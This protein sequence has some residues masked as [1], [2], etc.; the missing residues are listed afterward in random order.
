VKILI[1]VIVSVF[2][3][4]VLSVGLAF[5]AIKH[6]SN[7]SGGG[8]AVRV[9]PAT[10]GDLT[11]T[12][13][14][15]GTIESKTKV[16]I[17]ARVSARIIDLPFKEGDSVTKGDPNANPPIP[18]SVLVKLDAT[19]LEAQLKSAQAHYL[20]QKAQIRVAQANIASQKSQID[21][22]RAQLEDAQRDLKR[23]NELLASKDVSQS[24]VDT[25]QAKVDQLRASLEASQHSLEGL[26]QNLQV[27]QFELE[28]ADAAISQAKDNLS[29]TTITSP[30]DGVVT[31]VNSEVGELVV[32]GTMNNAGTVIMEVADLS[33]MLLKARVDES[34]IAQVKVGQKAVVRVPAYDD[35]EIQGE[36]TSVA[37]AETVD[38]QAGNQRYFKAEIL[39]DTKGQ[40]IISGLNADVDIQTAT[41][42]DVV[43]VPT[44]AVLGRPLDQ[45][46]AGIRNAPEVDSTK[47]T[48][49]VVYRLIN[50]KTVI[51]PVTVGASDVT[52]TVIKSGLKE[53]DP[54]ITGPFKVLD[55]L[56]DAQPMHSDGTSTTKPSTK[57]TTVPSTAPA[58][59]PATQTTTHNATTYKEVTM[60]KD[61]APRG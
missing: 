51:T 17:S 36:V 29:Y 6:G 56:A 22:S 45:I 40:R 13:T 47:T 5:V 57:P 58:T 61:Q 27:S 35:K 8:M 24:V 2:V 53:G 32:I 41:Y 20:G 21:S 3:I 54:V 26:E 11:E 38:A 25:A 55:T 4:G 33:K 48:Q 28:V 39:L 46:P 19:D 50:G 52:Q 1:W 42:R 59:Q 34:A 37:L 9:E 7:S 12:I 30:I 10:L 23:Q 16:S 18:P 14:A 60:D 31:R 49:T 15:P 44:Q 43:M